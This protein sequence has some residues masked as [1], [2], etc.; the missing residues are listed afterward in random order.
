[1]SAPRL[2]VN[3]SRKPPPMPETDIT[4]SNSRRL[5]REVAYQSLYMAKIGGLSQTEAQQIAESRHTLSADSKEFITNLVTG[6]IAEHE[7]LDQQLEPLLAEGWTLSRIAVS[8]HVILHIA[9]YELL[10]LPDMPPKVTIS[11]AVDLAKRFGS[12]ESGR[13]VNGVLANL[14]VQSPKS[15][16]EAPIVD[17][18]IPESEVI[19]LDFAPDPDEEPTEEPIEESVTAGSW[20][21]KRDDEPI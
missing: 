20:V 15:N 3:S 5:A 2:S 7:A 21:I 17:D 11:Q 10:H 14:L 12:A 9:A 16:W 4:P 18:S 19:E 13:F 6:V 8:D 1:M